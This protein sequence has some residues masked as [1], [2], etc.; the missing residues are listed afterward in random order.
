VRLP[1]D[2]LT[3]LQ[4]V[5]AEGA[6]STWLI[7]LGVGAVAGVGTAVAQSKGWLRGIGLK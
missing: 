1:S 3:N 7:W 2:V 5:K 4:P 6:S